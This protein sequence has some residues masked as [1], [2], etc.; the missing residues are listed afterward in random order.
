MLNRLVQPASRI[1]NALPHVPTSVQVA[2]F[3]EISTTLPKCMLISVGLDLPDVI[4][5]LY[6]AAINPAKSRRD[7]E[8]KSVTGTVAAGTYK[9]KRL[10]DD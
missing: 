3:R 6:R 9:E 2:K 8:D 4:V 7:R 5:P 1:E 10:L